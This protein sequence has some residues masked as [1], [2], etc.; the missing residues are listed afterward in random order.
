MPFRVISE[1][2][3]IATPISK[4]VQFDKCVAFFSDTHCT[5]VVLDYSA[6]A[7]YNILLHAVREPLHF[8]IK[9]PFRI[10]VFKGL[11]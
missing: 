11:I 5:N 6:H 3:N 4:H 2:S 10:G 8:L 7:Q 9:D 1:I